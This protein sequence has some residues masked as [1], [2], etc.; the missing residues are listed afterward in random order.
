[1]WSHQLLPECKALAVE[2]G[3]SS[4]D[5][6]WPLW[7]DVK[8][9]S[10]VNNDRTRGLFLVPDPVF[11]IGR[12]NWKS[13]RICQIFDCMQI[14]MVTTTFHL[15]WAFSKILQEAVAVFIYAAR[16]Q[17]PL[18]HWLFWFFNLSFP[19]LTTVHFSSVFF[20]FFPNTC[21]VWKHRPLFVPTPLLIT[22]EITT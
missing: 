18:S 10:T 8:N 16:S 3:H 5:M 4:Q 22:R 2:G 7:N 9:V 12:L 14:A 15:L 17:V 6:S 13:C 21:V 19:F 1:M 20:F 11:S